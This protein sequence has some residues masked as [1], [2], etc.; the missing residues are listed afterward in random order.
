MVLLL[1]KILKNIFKFAIKLLWLPFALIVFNFNFIK[2][3]FKGVDTMSALAVNWATLI[4][5]G[6]KTFDEV[7]RK[8]K[9]QV[10]EVLIV[11][12]CED[13]ITDDQYKPSK[14]QA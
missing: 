8:L 14:P 12:G 11:L 4:Q 13:L 3:Y 2:N 10:A 9:P 5:D 7:P 1:S 6:Y